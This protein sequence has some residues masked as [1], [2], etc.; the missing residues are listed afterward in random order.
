[1]GVASPINKSS[2][3]DP[4]YII[5]LGFQIKKIIPS[6]DRLK[7]S[8][9][10]YLVN[11]LRPQFKRMYGKC[12]TSKK[13][14]NFIYKYV[15]PD[16]TGVHLVQYPNS[17]WANL[18]L[19]DVSLETQIRVIELL[20]SLIPSYSVAEDVSVTEFELAIDFFPRFKKDVPLLCDNLAS[21]VTLKYA[22]PGSYEK[23]KTTHY[24]G[25]D[26]HSHDGSKGIRIYPKESEVGIFVRLENEPH[27]PYLR[28]RIGFF[29]LPVS[30]GRF[31]VS[32]FVVLRDQ[33]D[34][35]SRERLRGRIEKK[36]RQMEQHKNKNPLWFT[37]IPKH[38]VRRIE[39]HEFVCNQIDEFRE[40]CNKYG[41]SASLNSYFPVSYHHRR[42]QKLVKVALENVDD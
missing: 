7:L 23:F 34:S 14:D 5:F 26:G 30:P 41:L 1:M 17:I 11:R 24:F 16:G 29:D 25:K 4:R 2:N 22:R 12:K 9:S 37:S 10:D 35:K 31:D 33:I 42:L 20:S 19:Y 27:K 28:D 8:I 21:C 32:N 15:S 36:L 40:I 18:D 3:D 13:N 39:K 38:E 6:I